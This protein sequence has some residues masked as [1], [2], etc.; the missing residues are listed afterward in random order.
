MISKLGYVGFAQNYDNGNVPGPY[1]GYGCCRFDFHMG[2]P[3]FVKHMWAATSDNGLAAMAYGP[4]SVTARVADGAEVSIRQ[5]TDYPFGEQLRFTLTMDQTLAFPLKFRIPVWCDTPEIKVNGKAET[6]IEAGSFYTINRSWKNKDVITIHFPMPIVVNEEVNNSVSI[7]RGPLVFALKID[8][9]RVE[10]NNYGNGFTENEVLPS[11]AWNYALL[12]N[13]DDPESSIRVVESA[14]PENPYVQATSP[15]KLIVSAKKVPAWSY[16]H[17]GR[18]AIDPPYSPVNPE[19]EVE[20][21]TLVPYGAET[22]RATC[23]PYVG[24]ENLITSS[25]AE[26][27]TNGGKGWVQYGGSFYIKDDAYI[28][29]NVEASH[30]CSKSVHTATQFSDF[31]YEADV[32]L[33]SEQGNAGLM[34]RVNR[35]SFGPDDYDGYYV[36]LDS[37]NNKVELGKANGSWHALISSP[38]DIDVDRWYH[39]KLVANGTNIKVYVDNMLTPKIDY[40]DAS[41]SSGSVGLRSWSTLARWD[42]ISVSSTGSTGTETVTSD[43]DLRIYPNPVADDLVVTIARKGY[44]LVYDASGKQLFSADVLPGIT[45]LNTKGYHNGIYFLKLITEEGTACIPITS[46]LKPGGAFGLGNNESN[47]MLINTIAHNNLSGDS[48]NSLGQNDHI[49]GGGIVISRNSAIESA[50]TKLTDGDD[51]NHMKLTCDMT[52]DFLAPAA[53][54]GYTADESGMEQMVAASYHLSANSR[55]IDAGDISYTNYPVCDLGVQPRLS[56]TQIDMGAYE[57]QSDETSTPSLHLP[58]ISTLI[59]ENKLHVSGGEKGQQLKLFNIEGI[60]V[61]AQEIAG[62]NE[63]VVIPLGQQGIYFMQVNPICCEINEVSVY[64]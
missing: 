7:Q 8:E 51:I 32:Q 6:G 1:S 31:I 24:V 53:I 37:E 34:F 26:D 48:Y 35:V 5:Q 11:S 46:Q 13:K 47:L 61:H 41:F 27:F 54:I 45:T 33:N 30:P 44:M 64:K 57:F 15:V 50:S 28:A 59:L 55:C 20:E 22:L 16:A 19:T 39:I 63:A 58:H 36:G 52:P 3:Y 2:Y 18:I 10:R 9:N 43:K 14:M 12:I 49:N 4:S 23:L 21:L 56:G 42:N 25:F 38:V 62:D 60:L 40:S 29:T 17:N